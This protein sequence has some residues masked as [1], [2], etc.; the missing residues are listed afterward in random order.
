MVF[1]TVI[2][3]S[4][5]HVTADQEIRQKI[6]KILETWEAGQNQMLVKE[7]Y[8]MF[9]QYLSASLRGDL[10]EHRAQTFHSLVIRGKFQTA[11]H[12]VT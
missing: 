8:C 12:W 3:K 2:L 10:E 5:R 4:E 1:Q 11:V 6:G 9:K 7:T